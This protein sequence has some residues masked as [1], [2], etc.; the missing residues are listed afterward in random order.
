MELDLRNVLI[1]GRVMLRVERELAAGCEA[2]AHAV[3]DGRGE[4][5]SS[6]DGIDRIQAHGRHHV[7]GRHL[8]AVFV[9]GQAVEVVV[10]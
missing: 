9:A 3:E 5:I 6:A 2:N 7:P 4:H 1:G 8:A 10:V